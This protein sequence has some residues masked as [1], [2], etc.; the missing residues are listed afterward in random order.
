MIFAR[1]RVEQLAG[2]AEINVGKNHNQAQLAQYR[3][4]ILDHA[5][6]AEGPGRDAAHASAL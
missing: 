6:A 3:Q 2:P 4:Q 1:R 5:R